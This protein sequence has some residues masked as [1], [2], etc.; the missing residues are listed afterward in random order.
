MKTKGMSHQLAALRRM[1]GQ[2]YFAMLMDMGSGKS[3]CCLAD[4]E[5]LYSS[6][7]ID[8]MLVLAPKGVHTNWV[9]REIPT[10]MGDSVIARAWSS[11][12]S[13]SQRAHVEE[14]FQVRE[15]GEQ[16]PLRILTINFD[17][18][19]RDEGYTFAKRFLIATR[20]VIV[21]DES[22]R[23]KNLKSGRTV[24]AISLRRLARYARICSGLPVP[25][26][27]LDIFA[28]A[29]FLEPEGGLL[30]TTSYRAFVAE[31]AQV[32][33]ANHPMMKKMI[34]KNP[35]TAFAQVI[36]RDAVTGSPI[37]RNLDKLQ[38]LIE[39]FSFRVLKEDCLDLPPKIYENVYFDL[40]APQMRAYKLMEDQ[41]RIE[42]EGDQS[43]S[44][45]KLNAYSKLQQITS[46][47]VIQKTGN[48][49]YVS[50]KNPRL[51]ALIDLNE[52]MS[53][54]FIVWATFREELKAI[55]NALRKEGRTVVEYHGGINDKTREEAIDA[56]QNGAAEVFVAQPKAGGIG[57]T[58]TAASNVIYYSN[59]Y[60]L[61]DR[62]QSED[63]SHRKGTNHKVTYI[64]II[65]T[66]TIDEDISQA[67]QRK[68]NLASV[69]LNDSARLNQRKRAT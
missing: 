8:A 14:I 37:Y 53:G 33:D 45:A 47:F 4:A 35:R 64:D 15:E 20:A 32:L 36:A 13:K 9:K 60:N 49:I 38:K 41:Y 55:A 12:M 46:G 30:G 29:E 2:K 52:S 59:S 65:A 6:G 18:L 42:L 50:D 5:R 26:S 22:S 7:Q 69:V 31:F 17:A 63:R 10:H 67:L 56:F 57:L 62:L 44:V 58:L 23:L 54:K 21:A 34:Q 28:Q 48:V 19:I 43:E 51:A 25:N 16:T 27:P 11:G 68:E 40:G 39:P 24:A 3:W 1:N 66:N 61:E